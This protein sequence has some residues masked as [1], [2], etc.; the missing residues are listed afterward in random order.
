MIKYNSPEEWKKKGTELFGE[1]ALDWKFKCPACGKVSSGHDFKKVGADAM[2]LTQKCIGNFLDGGE[3]DPENNEK[4]CNWK[5]YGLFRIGDIVVCEGHELD[6][7][8]FAT[9]EVD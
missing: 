7:F 8:P 9:E 2:D 6:V 4:G 3:P 1:K 5:A